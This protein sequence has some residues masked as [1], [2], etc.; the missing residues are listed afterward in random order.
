MQK[1]KTS[2]V[3][4][5]MVDYDRTKQCRVTLAKEVYGF[6]HMFH[7]CSKNMRVEEVQRA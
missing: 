4:A 3:G 6:T 5:I 2:A 1:A 7:G